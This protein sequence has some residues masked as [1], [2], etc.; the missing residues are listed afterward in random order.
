MAIYTVVSKTTGKEIYQYEADA[1]IE[2]SGMEFATH[3][4]DIMNQP[5]V[6][7][8]LPSVYEGRRVLSKIEFRRLF[9]DLKRP[10]VDEFNA[11]FENNA[12]LNNDQKRSIRSGLEDY[13]ATDTVNL[14]DASTIGMVNLYAQIGL[15]TSA[16]AQGILNG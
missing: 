5:V 8:P 14:D 4:H 7:Q 13:K 12:I 11:T 3:T 16:E 6:N 2:W 9:P 15:I 10:Y 1:P